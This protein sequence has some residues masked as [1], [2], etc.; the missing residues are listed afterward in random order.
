MPATQ[1]SVVTTL[2]VRS[3]GRL[4]YAVNRAVLAA[5]FQQ[6][7]LALV[8]ALA[9]HRQP[10]VARQPF[11]TKSAHATADG[12]M[13]LYA[14]VRLRDNGNCEDVNDA[15]RRFR[16]GSLLA[17]FRLHKNVEGGGVHLSLA[18]MRRV[19]W[20]PGRSSPQQVSRPGGVVV[21]CAAR[22]GRQPTLLACAARRG[23]VHG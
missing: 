9:Q 8:Q 20:L 10:R 16:R 11:Q 13:E 22:H 23:D 18:L 17:A 19:V 21:A 2:G 1:A 15:D 6:V 7:L 14:E 4:Q 3:A 12:D 5:R